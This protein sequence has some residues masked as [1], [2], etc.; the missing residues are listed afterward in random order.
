MAPGELA[1]A[2]HRLTAQLDSAA[3]D[4]LRDEFGLSHS[5][6]GFLMPLLEHTELDVTSLAAALHVSVPAVSK[7]VTWFTERDLVR[8]GSHPDG[9]RRVSLRLTP[10]GRRLAVRA[11]TRLRARL[12]EL[13]GDWQQ[14]RLELL[15][16]LVADLS[17]TV[18]AAPAADS[19]RGRTA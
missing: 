16:D 10:S 4:L 13:V 7:R 19:A 11:S 12:D 6:L 5:Q 3:D 15:H 1:G 14:D 9:G 8:S 17:A 2:L 18:S